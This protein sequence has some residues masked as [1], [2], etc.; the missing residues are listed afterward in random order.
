M[1]WVIGLTV[2]VFTSSVAPL[3]AAKC[4][5]NG[6]WY[7]Y[8]APECRTNTGISP[9]V[10]EP[11]ETG[12]QSGQIQANFE[13]LPEA[14]PVAIEWPRNWSEASV[15]ASNYC[16]SKQSANFPAEYCMIQEEVGFWA[17]HGKFGLP[18]EVLVEVR[19]RCTEHQESFSQRSQCIRSEAMDYPKFA[20]NFRMPD[21]FESQAREKCGETYKSYSARA[22]CMKREERN[23]KEKYGT[24]SAQAEYTP[25][26]QISGTAIRKRIG[27]SAHG[28]FS[29]PIP[30]EFTVNPALNTAVVD[31]PRSSL[32][33][34]PGYIGIRS[35]LLGIDA[36]AF[37]SSADF[38]DAIENQTE[39]I[40]LTI[41]KPY[42][43]DVAYLTVVGSNRVSPVE[44]VHA[45]DGEKA[46]VD[47]DIHL[48]AGKRYL[49]EFLVN[50]K[51]GNKYLVT[52]E[53]GAQEM[54]DE[55]GFL[56]SLRVIVK[57]A[58]NGWTKIGVGPQGQGDFSL[59]G[60]VVTSSDLS[61]S[62]STV[63]S[64]EN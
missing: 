34:E 27:V 36:R 14:M 25:S 30:P 39:T 51:P 43:Q 55:P 64:E 46:R 28:S 32:Q 33:P 12:E 54:A 29:S 53:S 7:S 56:G 13:P 18:S 22:S 24:A 20:G 61:L 17:M 40:I 21:E 26:A 5:V 11:L 62:D 45:L 35:H 49:V 42:I 60:V 2:L 31:Q 63:I 6:K 57:A 19:S 3:H 16:V 59:T 37:T 1:K 10:P 44:G 38:L 8:D 15:H 4:K 48:E 23:F 41:E 47:L 52:T 50:P 58:G 9:E